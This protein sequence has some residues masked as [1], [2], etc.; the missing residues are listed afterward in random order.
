MSGMHPSVIV[1]CQFF[2]MPGPYRIHRNRICMDAHRLLWPEHTLLVSK[3]AVARS[4]CQDVSPCPA[5]LKKVHV[6]Y[7]RTLSTPRMSLAISPR[8]W[9]LA[10]SSITLPSGQSLLC[11]LKSCGDEED[12]GRMTFAQSLVWHCVYSSG[13]QVWEICRAWLL[14]FF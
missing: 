1:Q 9:L 5:A 11:T 2:M 14:S 8:F 12:D 4:A 7:S 6:W 13:G 3:G 10:I